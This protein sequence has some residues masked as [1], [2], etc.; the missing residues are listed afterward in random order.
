M[1]MKSSTHL[2]VI[3]V[4]LFLV[5]SVLSSFDSQKKNIKLIDATSQKSNSG[6]KGGINSTEYYFKIKI[7]TSEKINFDSLWIGTKV[8]NPFIANNKTVVSSQGQSPTYSKN[9]TI[10]LRIS[11]VTS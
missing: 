2:S 3:C 6:V 1:P 5:F 8:F 9:D 10:T 4:F 7:L 11:E